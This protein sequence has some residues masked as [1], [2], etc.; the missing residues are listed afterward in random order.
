VKIVGKIGTCKNCGAEFAKKI[1]KQTF[2]TKKCRFEFLKKPTIQIGVCPVCGKS[3]L[4]RNGNHLFCDDN[5]WFKHTDSKKQIK[6]QKTVV[7]AKCVICGKLLDRNN[8]KVCSSPECIKE[9]R[10]QTHQYHYRGYQPRKPSSVKLTPEMKARMKEIKEINKLRE[11][12][13]LRPISAGIIQCRMCERD[14]FSEDITRVKMC[15]PCK[16][17]ANEIETE[18][19]AAGG[20]KQNRRWMM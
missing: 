4:K 18:N 10:K 7:T 3:F 1:S 15:E 19:L 16:E 9:R 13:D 11:S 6:T 14:F 8:Q 17:A 5:C 12:M 20:A 2:C